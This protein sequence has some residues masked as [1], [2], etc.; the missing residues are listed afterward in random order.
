LTDEFDIAIAGAGI[1]G[2]TAAITAARLGRKTLLL[3]GHVPGGLLLSINRIDGY[4]G[5]PEG[6]P[7]YDLCPMAQD[8]AVAAGAELV[9]GEVTA[10]EQGDDY[11]LL[12]AG[13]NPYQARTLI[14]ATGAGLKALGVPGEERLQGKGV[15]HCASCDAP[16][17]RHRT[18]VVIGGGDSAAQEALTLAESAAHVIILHRGA[19]LKAQNAYQQSLRAHAAVS[20][21]YHTVVEEI[22]GDAAVTGVRFRDLTTG[23]SGVLDADAVFAYI[24]LKPNTGLVKDLVQL[25]ETGS[26]PVDAML[27]TERRGLFAAGIVRTGA[28]GRA[29]GSAGDGALAAQSADAYLNTRAWRDT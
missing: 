28:A 24:G 18:V 20:V 22:L 11:F 13:G 4:P 14:I 1:A 5:F 12:S 7:G 6:V 16:M 17:L 2:L 27:R 25:D 15:S 10:I 19:A 3:T 29:A 26:I 21:R 23:T 9:S 8:Q